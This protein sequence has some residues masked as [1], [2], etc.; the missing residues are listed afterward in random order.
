MDG[1]SNNWIS[2]KVCSILKNITPAHIVI[3][4]SYLNRREIS[5]QQ[6]WDNEANKAWCELYTMLQK[7]DWPEMSNIDD[8]KNLP[9]HIQHEMALH[10]KDP[11]YT[12]EERRRTDLDS[13]LEQDL[14]NL[15][16]CIDQINQHNKNSTIINSFIPG[17]SA[18]SAEDLKHI[19]DNLNHKFDHVIPYFKQ[20]DHAR[21]WHH[22]D[23]VTATHFVDQLVTTLT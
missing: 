16:F 23:I 14:Q 21:D 20:L 8:S 6:I 9:E 19:I 4:W 7:P 3:H 1:A 15:N 18:G 13:S 12:D 17:F 10:W 2:R 22:Y 11:E 5:D